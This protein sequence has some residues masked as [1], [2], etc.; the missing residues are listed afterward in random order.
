M[1]ELHRLKSITDPFRS[2][3]KL[4]P[5]GPRVEEFVAKRALE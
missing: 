5:L 1:Y 4:N 3:P 2:H